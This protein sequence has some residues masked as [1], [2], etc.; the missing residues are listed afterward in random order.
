MV[1]SKWKI[2]CV[3]FSENMNHPMA[4]MILLNKKIVVALPIK[5]SLALTF[6][7]LIFL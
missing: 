7:M 3:D 2:I 5:I 6:A 1:K 4:R